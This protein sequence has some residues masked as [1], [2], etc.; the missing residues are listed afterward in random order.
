MRLLEVPKAVVRSW[1]REHG[2]LTAIYTSPDRVPRYPFVT[3]TGI[4]YI[5]EED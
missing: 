5:D 4:A 3:I 1:I 2:G